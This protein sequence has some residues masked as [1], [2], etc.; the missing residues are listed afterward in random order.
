MGNPLHQGESIGQTNSKGEVFNVS[1]QKPV[2]DCR[3][4]SCPINIGIIICTIYIYIYIYDWLVVWN[5]WIIFPSTGNVIIP[6]DE[7]I[8][9]RGMANNHQPDDNHNGSGNPQEPTIRLLK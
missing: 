3:G 2:D 5:I 7:L 9:F 6:T 8:F 1:V 4:L